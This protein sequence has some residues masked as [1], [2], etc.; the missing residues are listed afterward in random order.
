I[1]YTQ[2]IEEAGCWIL[3]EELGCEYLYRYGAIHAAYL[4]HG[5]GYHHFFHG[6]IGRRKGYLVIVPARHKGNGVRFISYIAD[7][8]FLCS[9]GYGQFEAALLVSTGAYGGV[10]YFDSGKGYGLIILRVIY[11][12]L[13]QALRMRGEAGQ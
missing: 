4:F 7:D 5:S 2:R 8:E 13:Y 9:G 6:V 10:V 1:H 11:S 3:F 12:A